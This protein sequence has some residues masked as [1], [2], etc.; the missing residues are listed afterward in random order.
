MCSVAK[1]QKDKQK[2]E[3]QRTD[4]DKPGKDKPVGGPVGG[5]S[6]SGG[7][8]GAVMVD[9]KHL[10]NYRVVQRNLVY[11]I[12]MPASTAT[13]EI[14]R[15]PEYFGQYGKITK[16]VIHK[17]SNISHSTVSVYITFANKEDAKAAIQALD[18]FFLDGHQLRA[19]FGTTKYCN[20]FVR[21]VS[22]GNPECVYLHDFGEDEDRYTKEDI[23]VRIFC[24]SSHFV[25]FYGCGFVESKHICHSSQPS[26]QSHPIIICHVA[27]RQWRSK[28]HGEETI[29]RP[30]PSSARVHPGGSFS[31]W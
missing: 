12:G 25:E 14:L 22:C 2:K 30:G 26:F 9:R 16:T 24:T 13:E 1:S 11:V 28:W 19:S 21:G 5:P 6:A 20:S 4:K 31:S 8:N 15:R 3:K 23:V 27:H 10:H 7:M 18:G 29:R 17:N